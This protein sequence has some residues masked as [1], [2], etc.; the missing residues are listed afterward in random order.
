MANYQLTTLA[1]ED[2][3]AV[4]RYT[5]TKWG[6]E[7]AKRYQASL[8]NCFQAIGQGEIGGRTLSRSVLCT[9]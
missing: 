8:E 7:Q 2:L 9:L 3:R 4:A 1:R 6:I 5:L